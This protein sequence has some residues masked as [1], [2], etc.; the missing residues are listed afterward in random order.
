MAGRMTQPSNANAHPGMVDQNPAHHSKEEAKAIREAK[1][2]AKAQ[3]YMER[4]VNLEKVAAFERAEK[5]RARDMDHKANNPV[6]LASQPK[7]QMIRKCPIDVDGG[8]QRCV[9]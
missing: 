2:A 3:T 1:A 7:A 8:E 5:Q 4:K 6:K 9:N